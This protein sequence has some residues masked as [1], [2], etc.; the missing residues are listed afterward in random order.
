MIHAGALAGGYAPADFP[1]LADVF[2]V[3]V[4]L[5]GG[6]GTDGGGSSG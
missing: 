6:G 2:R 4:S 3:Y 1:E 5:L